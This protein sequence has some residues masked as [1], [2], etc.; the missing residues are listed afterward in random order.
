MAEPEP[1]TNLSSQAARLHWAALKEQIVVSSVKG[2]DK[3]AQQLKEGIS[4]LRHQDLNIKATEGRKRPSHRSGMQFSLKY[5][6]KPAEK[7]ELHQSLKCE[8]DGGQTNAHT[9]NMKQEV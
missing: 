5:W 4:Y 7:C 2:W 6:S 8:D 1:H 9:G 3:Q